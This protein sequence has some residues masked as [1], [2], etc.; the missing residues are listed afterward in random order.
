MTRALAARGAHGWVDEVDDEE[1]PRHLNPEERALAALRQG[2]R[3]EALAILMGQYGTPV[4]R[5]C[6]KVLRSRTLADDVHQVVFT[7]AFEDLG[8]FSGSSTFRAWLYAIA[9]HRCLDALKWRRRWYARFVEREEPAEEVD[10]GPTG[11][12][13][14]VSRSLSEALDACLGKLQPHVRTAVTLRFQEGFTYEEM[15]RICGE[16]AATLQARVARAMPLL[17]RCLEGKGVRL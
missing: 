11:E 2:D 15:S 5:Y 10:P 4:Y 7:Q 16:R 13:E 6:Y 9:N 3:R 1:A 14:V 12:D 17:R 8:S